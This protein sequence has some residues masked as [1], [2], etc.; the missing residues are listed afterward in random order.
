MAT[1]RLGALD[2]D[3]SSNTVDTNY[4]VYTVP[5]STKSSINI[6]VCNR[7]ASTCKV[8]VALIDGAIGDVADEDYIEYDV[9]IPLGGILERT[10]IILEA[11]ETVLMRSDTA[12]V[13]MVITG[14]EEAV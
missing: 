5:A 2:I 4:G 12:G 6:S 1:G 11:A 7:S 9:V 3:G 10:G 8:R 13:N 14:V